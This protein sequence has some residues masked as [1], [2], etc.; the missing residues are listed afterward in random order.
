MKFSAPPIPHWAVDNFRSPFAAAA[1]FCQILSFVVVVIAP[2]LPAGLVVVAT[3]V[4]LATPLGVLAAIEG[5]DKMHKFGIGLAVSQMVIVVAILTMVIAPDEQHLPADD[6]GDGDAVFVV[7]CSA[8]SFTLAVVELVGLLMARNERISRALGYTAQRLRSPVP[9]ESTARPLDWFR[10]P[11]PVLTAGM[12]IWLASV[13]VAAVA[14]IIVSMMLDL[15]VSLRGAPALTDIMNNAINLLQFYQVVVPPFIVLCGTAGAL[16][17]GRQFRTDVTALMATGI[18]PTG[19]TDNALLKGKVSPI[20]VPS[21]LGRALAN[22]FFSLMVLLFIIFFVFTP[23]VVLFVVYDP[24]FQF[25]IKL[26]FSS[27]G[28]LLGKKVW[29]WLLLTFVYGRG[30]P[31][32]IL[33]PRRHAIVN[34]IDIIVT[35]VFDAGV[36]FFTVV[37]AIVANVIFAF[38]PD[39][40]LFPRGWELSDPSYRSYLACVAMSAAYTN[41]IATAAVEILRKPSHRL[42]RARK[43]WELAITLSRNPSLI[44]HRRKWHRLVAPPVALPESV[45]DGSSSSSTD[46]SL[47][48]IELF[49]PVSA[50]RASSDNSSSSGYSQ[51]SKVSN[52]G[53]GTDPLIFFESQ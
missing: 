12:L 11:V 5:A 9:G 24:F 36:A 41:P 40:S 43:R 3:L 46:G 52:G 37:L 44:A 14:F 20:L 35:F 4:W 10:F 34:G 8:S 22:A 1:S 16:G 17:F 2:G 31:L 42:T 25:V 28:S 18:K 39:K 50:R 23:L 26:G 7:A 19:L 38:R 6:D 51:I 15:A 21:L 27:L 45:L 29:R 53:E 32:E 13:I 33:H 47:S 48:A 30:D 49:E